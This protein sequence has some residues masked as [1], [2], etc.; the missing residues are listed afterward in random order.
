VEAANFKGGYNSGL[1][2]VSNNKMTELT[3]KYN[4]YAAT[5]KLEEEKKFK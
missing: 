4:E 1:E 3:A 5:L 2:S